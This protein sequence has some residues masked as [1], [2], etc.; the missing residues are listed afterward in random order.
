MQLAGKFIPVAEITSA[1]Q[2]SH[3]NTNNHIPE[4]EMFTDISTKTLIN[5]LL[6]E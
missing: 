2:V 3:I 4:Q 6:E 1:S 5:K